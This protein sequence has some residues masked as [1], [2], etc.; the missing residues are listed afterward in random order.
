MKEETKVVLSKPVMKEQLE[1]VVREL[2][3]RGRSFVICRSTKWNKYVSIEDKY[4]TAGRLNRELNG[5]QMHVGDTVADCI[6]RTKNDVEVDPHRPGRKEGALKMGKKV[7]RIEQKNGVLFFYED[8]ELVNRLT[9]THADTQERQIALANA[10]GELLHD[11]IY[12]DGKK[13]G[14]EL[15]DNDDRHAYCG[16]FLEFLNT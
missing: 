8:G 15:H 16:T 14:C 11:A 3:V 9:F 12:V 1:V 5:V 2:V 10:V 4:I 6:D 7:L 13:V